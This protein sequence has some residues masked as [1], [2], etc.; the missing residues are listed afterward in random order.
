M[1]RKVSI[2]MLVL[3]FAVFGQAVAQSSPGDLFNLG[4]RQFAEGDY[5]RAILNY[6]EVL[7]LV[8]ESG[9]AHL[10]R[11]LTYYLMGED[12]RAVE[13]YTEALNLNPN[14]AY[15]HFL[16]GLAYMTMGDSNRAV[17]DFTQEIALEPLNANAYFYRGLI[18]YAQENFGRAINDFQ[19]AVRID[20]HYL[21]ANLAL[22]VALFRQTMLEVADFLL[23]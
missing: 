6:D 2:I 4:N 16:R 14:I 20:K 23:E 3:V 15:A 21:E 8:H 5:S 9:G 19:A 10:I 18:F 7:F 17:A 1:K 12:R 22:A 11:G 13:D